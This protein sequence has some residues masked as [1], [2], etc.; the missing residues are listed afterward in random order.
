MKNR[1]LISNEDLWEMCNDYRTDTGIR[2]MNLDSHG[3]QRYES[4]L[5]DLGHGFG[6]SCPI[7]SSSEHF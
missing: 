1:K 2:D 3:D 6:F 7:F 5:S 4:E